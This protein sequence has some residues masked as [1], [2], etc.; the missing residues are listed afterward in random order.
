VWLDEVVIYNLDEDILPASRSL[1]SRFGERSESN[2]IF[3][4]ANGDIYIPHVDCSESKER[5]EDVS[6]ICHN[7]YQFAGNSVLFGH[8]PSS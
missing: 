6:G 5:V 8:R 4:L 2:R 3:I 1:A 7:D